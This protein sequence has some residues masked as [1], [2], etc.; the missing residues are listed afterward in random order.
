MTSTSGSGPRAWAVSTRSMSRAARLPS[1]N[2]STT[3]DGPRITSPPTNTFP[4]TRPCSSAVM[5]PLSLRCSGSHSSCWT[6]PM[7]TKMVSQATSRSVPGTSSGLTAPLSSF[8]SRAWQS[9]APVTCPSSESTRTSELLGARAT[10]SSRACSRSS[11][12][13]GNSSSDSNETITASPPPSRMADRAAAE[14]GLAEELQGASHTAGLDS[15]DR[16]SPAHVLAEGQEG[17]GVVA[18][19]VPADV[20]AG[21]DPAA[22]LDATE[23]DQLGD[24][25]VEDLLR[26]VPVRDA[27]PEHAARLV[28]CLE[29]DAGIATPAQVVRAGQAGRTGTDDGDRGAVER[30]QGSG[31][32]VLRQR[33]PVVTEEALDG[34]D[35]DRLVV[36]RPVARGLARVVAD[37][38][39]DRRHRV[40]FH[41]RQV[42]VEVALVLH[43]VQVLLDLLAGGARVVAGWRLVLIDR[44][45]GAEI[46]G[47]EEPLPFLLGRR[48]R[49]SGD[50]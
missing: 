37:P 30:G 39:G 35:P 18:Q 2:A 27:S 33:Q 46:T 23:R 7:A 4:S 40:V 41:D 26:Q 1:P 11:G 21:P 14:T 43:V 12:T 34:A 50:G 3:I 42:A 5:I 22:D 20:L 24:L 47:G 16:Q 29:D 31:D 45:E 49:H 15:L 13:I 48:R 38:A 25:G 32:R 28:Q 44:P 19:L 6:W 10:P 17:R 8:L 36:R 9:T